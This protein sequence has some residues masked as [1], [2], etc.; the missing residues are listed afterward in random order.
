MLTSFLDLV[1]NK[2]REG[3]FSIE[4]ETG[5]VTFLLF[6]FM[7][8]ATLGMNLEEIF[9]LSVVDLLPVKRMSYLTL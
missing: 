2:G 5:L 4:I 7:L 9:D 3:A 1:R 6:L 8:D